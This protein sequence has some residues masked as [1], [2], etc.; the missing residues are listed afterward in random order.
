MIDKI[1]F[2]DIDGVCTSTIETPGSYLNHNIN[3]YG[4]SPN[5]IKNLK[6][7]CQ[8]TNAKIIIS[9]SWRTYG[10]KP[11]GELN[12][13]KIPNPLVQLY[14]EFKDIIIGSLPNTGYRQ[15]G[16]ALIKWFDLHDFNGNYVILDD[17][18][19][20]N[21]GNILLY[22]IGKHLYLT[23]AKTGLQKSDCA[24]IIKMLNN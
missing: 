18:I 22:S 11:Y 12:G 6:Y 23:D 15:K 1:I 5:C 21:I 10:T 24:K 16:E 19:K 4:L 14:N 17:D 9:S 7:I 3:E 8:K 20:E 2:L 13:K